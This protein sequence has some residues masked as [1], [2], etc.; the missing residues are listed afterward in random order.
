MRCFVCKNSTERSLRPFRKPREGF[1][2][3]EALVGIVLIAAFASSTF[4]AVRVHNEQ[5][6]EAEDTL[7]ATEIAEQQL[8]NLMD[9]RGAITPL[10]GTVAGH[11]NWQW[12]VVPVRTQPLAGAMVQVAKYQIVRRGAKQ[13]VLVSVEFVSAAEAPKTRGRR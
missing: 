9:S 10:S 7:V 4:L 3:I 1:T 2:L 5:L 11:E 6:Q 8:A 13:R 12:S